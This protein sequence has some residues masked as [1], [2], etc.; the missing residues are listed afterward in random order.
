[1]ASED[2]KRTFFVKKKGDITGYNKLKQSPV[3][4]GDLYFPLNYI[5]WLIGSQSVHVLAIISK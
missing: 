2:T 3:Y 4:L 1:M 5:L